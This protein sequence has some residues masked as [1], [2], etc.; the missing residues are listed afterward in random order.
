MSK[1]QVLGRGIYLQ[2][3]RVGVIIEDAQPTL[4]DEFRSRLEGLERPPSVA[5]L[6]EAVEEFRRNQEQELSSIDKEGELSAYKRGYL[7]GRTDEKRKWE[8]DE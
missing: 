1:L 7:Q 2:G 8:K 4:V 5:E 6:S 3:V